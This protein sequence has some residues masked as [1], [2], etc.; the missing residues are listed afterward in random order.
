LKLSY[1]Q[2][3]LVI[4]ISLILH[5][6]RKVEQKLTD[7][8]LLEQV[9][10]SDMEAFRMLF[11]RYQPVLFRQVLFQTGHT[12]LS[13]D[14]VQET[15]IRV[16]EHRRSIKPHLSFLGYV[17]RISRNL[18]RDNVKHQNIRERIDK[19]ISPSVLSENDDP[20]EALQLILLQEQITRIMKNDLPKRCREIFL[21]S[22]YEGKTHK[23]IAEMLHLSVRTVEHQILHA[24]NILRI[25]LER[26]E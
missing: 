16:W 6:H 13:H 14:I 19:G 5:S 25:K 23:E 4:I 22:R 15:F 20:S 12:D 3:I 17:F 21:L 7:T 9:K 8:Q 2:L 24:L 1:A 26:H 11:E 10:D 18:I